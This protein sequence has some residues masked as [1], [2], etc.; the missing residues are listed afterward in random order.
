[1]SAW[2]IKIAALDRVNLHGFQLPF[3]KF[4]RTVYSLSEQIDFSWGLS[5]RN[6]WKL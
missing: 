3:K 2:A 4:G 6:P 5:M 1:M